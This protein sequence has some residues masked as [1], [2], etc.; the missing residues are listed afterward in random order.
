MRQSIKITLLLAITALLTGCFKDVSYKTTYV[1]KP[2]QQATSGDMLQITPDAKLYAFAADTAQWS[3]ASYQDALDGVITSRTNPSKKISETVAVGEPY[4]REETEGWL[5]MPLELRTQLILA[6]DTQNQLYAI[7]QFETT[8][9][10]PFTYVTLI[11][12]PYKEGFTY[13]EGNWIFFNDN[14][15]PPKKLDCTVVP[16]LQTEENGLQTDPPSANTMAYSF[17]ADTTLWRIASYEDAAGGTITLKSDPKT[18]RE[19]PTYAFYEN[20]I[21]R[22]TVSNTPLMVVVVD[23]EH[24]RYA[25]SKQE[26]DLDGASPSFSIVFRLWRK[27]YLYVEDGWRVVDD[28]LK[29]VDPDP[30]IPASKIP[31]R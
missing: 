22:M 23:K 16:K 5:Q 8:E 24:R 6:V 9:N 1:L 2:L 31:N 13:K 4:Q 20:G 18:Q 28:S 14:Y 15:E 12:K 27:E 25:Y 19:N 21:Y 26:V 3:V 17:A 7:T 11:F 10:L 29:P 30:L